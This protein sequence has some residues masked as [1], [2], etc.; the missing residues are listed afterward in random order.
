MR[1]VVASHG[2]GSNPRGPNQTLEEIRP[3]VTTSPETRR[4]GGRPAAAIGNHVRRKGARQRTSSR[5]LARI[6]RRATP[7]PAPLSSRRNATAV[8][9]GG[10]QRCATIARGS[11]HRRNG[12]PPKLRQLAGNE[13]RHLARG[14]AVRSASSG[15]RASDSDTILKA[16]AR[17]AC[18]QRA[19]WCSSWLRHVRRRRAVDVR[20]H[21]GHLDLKFIE[22]RL[23]RQPAL[24]GLT[25]SARTDSPRRI[26]RK[27]F[28]GED[29]RRRRT[30]GGDDGV[31][32]EEGRRPSL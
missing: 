7:R 32:G 11:A 18:V 26:G 27:Q 9:E 2:P 19:H 4:S 16:S 14:G 1:S 24:E 12:R 17:P 3:A 15:V 31:Y 28:S 6:Q 5:H 10:A 22:T 8:R 25:R 20:R 13:A 30:A 23:L 21:F 29:G